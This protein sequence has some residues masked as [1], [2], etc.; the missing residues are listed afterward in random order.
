[1]KNNQIVLQTPKLKA[2]FSNYAAVPKNDLRNFYRAQE[3]NFNEQSFRRILYT[4]EK[5]QVLTSIGSGMYAFKEKN[6]AP[7]TQFSPAP[8]KKLSALHQTLAK[9]FPYLTF[10]CWETGLLH[11]FMLH[12]P[13]QQFMLIEV[14]KEACESVFNFLREKHPGK[15]F[16]DPDRA[17]MQRYVLSQPNA[18]L[19]LPL[20][21]Q[22]PSVNMKGISFP[23]L[24][25]ILADIFVNT[26]IFFAFQGRELATIYQN[27]FEMY[28]V[29]EKTLFRYASR[30]NAERKLLEF[31]QSQTKIQLALHVKKN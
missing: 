22:S 9:A 26:D 16:L 25:K 15:T 2:T 18:I 13:G 30:R 31:I 24:E 4:L 17:M 11:E 7:R 27:A 10:L 20:I 8:S 12:Q 29:N 23:K 28:W 19:I 3:R 5:E 6:A 14:E 1:M 21:S